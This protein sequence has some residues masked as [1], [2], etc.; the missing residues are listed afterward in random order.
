MKEDG[1]ACVCVCGN[2]VACSNLH[3]HTDVCMSVYIFNTIRT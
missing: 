3:I 2:G 1:Y